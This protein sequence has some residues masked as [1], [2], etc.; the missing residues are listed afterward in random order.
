MIKPSDII[1]SVYEDKK[2]NPYRPNLVVEAQPDLHEVAIIDSRYQHD[3]ML[4]DRS[5]EMVTDNIYHKLYG[6]LRGHI[7]EMYAIAM[8]KMPYGQELDM[9]REAKKK[10]DQIMRGET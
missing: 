3:Q 5:K 8:V 9:V 1:I 10:I 4:I 7:E 6:D 2:T